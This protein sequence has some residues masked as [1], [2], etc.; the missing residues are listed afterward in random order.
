M[1]PTGRFT[2][3]HARHDQLSVSQPPR[4]GPKI[5]ARPHTAAKRPWYRPRSAGEKMSPTMVNRRPITMPAPTP[6]R[7]RN[8]ISC[9]MP[10]IGRNVSLPA[11]PNRAQ[12]RIIWI[13]AI[14]LIVAWPPE[15]GKSL[16]VKA[17]NRAADPFD[18]LP[19]LP[20]PLPM[21]LDDN[22]DAVAAHDLQASEFYRVYASGRITRW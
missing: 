11:A 16:L 1:A 22:G 13:V 9:P 19:D 6:C 17:I 8:R 20:P 12:W 3:K 14:L 5:D 7:P 10:S 15:E 4:V 2:Q 21:G 18:A